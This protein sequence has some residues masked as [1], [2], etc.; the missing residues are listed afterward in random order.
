MPGVQL[1][2]SDVVMPGGISGFDLAAWVK[3]NRPAVRVLLT[4]GFTGEVARHG[5]EPAMANVPLL[6][7]PYALPELARAVREVL[8]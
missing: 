6:S 2:F 8:S 3:A 5:E 7:K 4:S 1:V